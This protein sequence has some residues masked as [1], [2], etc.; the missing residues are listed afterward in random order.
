M[1]DNAVLE[2]LEM[3]QLTCS[4]L[5]ENHARDIEKLEIEISCLRSKIEKD[6]NTMLVQMEK[7]DRDAER[8]RLESH[9][10]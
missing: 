8:E 3:F 4:H 2:A 9:S 10:A 6:L 7:E 5:R 1:N